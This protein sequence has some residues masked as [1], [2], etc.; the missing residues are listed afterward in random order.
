[1][2]TALYALLAIAALLPIAASPAAA[3]EASGAVYVVTHVDVTPPNTAQGLA[4]VKDQAAERSP[5]ARHD[6]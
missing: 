6:E 5:Q 4:I 1:M 3:Q 2:P